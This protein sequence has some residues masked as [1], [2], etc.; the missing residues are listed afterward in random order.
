MLSVERIVY[1][2]LGGWTFFGLPGFLFTFPLLVFVVFFVLCLVAAGSLGVL[3]R[4][5]LGASSNESSEL[6]S[7]TIF[8]STVNVSDR[9]HTIVSPNLI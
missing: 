1:K 6:S 2:P 8:R 3:P 9:P 5:F 4:L 7:R